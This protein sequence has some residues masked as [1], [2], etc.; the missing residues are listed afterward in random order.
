MPT[1][2]NEKTRI[3]VETAKDNIPQHIKENIHKQPPL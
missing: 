2:S 1:R 3:R